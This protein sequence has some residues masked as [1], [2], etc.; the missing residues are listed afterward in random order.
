MARQERITRYMEILKKRMTEEIP[1]EIGI[2]L[3]DCLM[4]SSMIMIKLQSVFE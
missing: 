2:S 1:S 4:K 3:T